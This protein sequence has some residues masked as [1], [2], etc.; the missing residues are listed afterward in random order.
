MISLR[1]VYMPIRRSLAS[2]SLA[3]LLPFLPASPGTFQTSKSNT[4]SCL[5]FISTNLAK[6]NGD[7][8]EYFRFSSKELVIKDGDTFVYSIFLDPR[9]PVAKGGVDIN[10]QDDGLPLRDLGLVDQEGIQA[11]GNGILQSAVGKWYT[12]RISLATSIGR[13][14]SDF[15]FQEEGDPD[16]TY[17]QFVADVY[18]EHADGSKTWIY[19]D[20][21]P[22]AGVIA[23]ENGYS[24][25]PTCVQVDRTQVETGK[26]LTPVIRAAVERGQAATKI[27]EIKKDIDLAKKYLAK[28][29]D[30]SLEG[31]VKEAETMLTQ[32]QTDSATLEQVEAVLHSAR[33]ALS[34][35]HPVMEKY[36]GHLVGHAHIDLQWLWEWQ[37]GIVFTHDTFNQAVKFMDEFPGFSFSQS[38]S[39]LYQ[40]TEQNYPDL[41]KK[42]QEKVHKGTWEIVGGRV[43]EGDTNMISLESHARQFLYGQRYFREKFGKT[44]VVG[45]EPDTFGHTAQMPQ[46]LKLGGC[47]YYYFCRGG[48]NKP[49]FWWS[50]LDG[51]KVLAFDE[52]ANGSWYNS[53][54][55]YRQFEEMLNFDKN[56]GS[57]DDLWVYGVGNHG[58]GPT[59]EQIEMALGWM[60][61][62]SKPKVKFSTATQFFNKLETYDLTKIPTVNTDL[63]P[64]FDGCYTSH[65]EI[66]QL[67]RDAEALTTSAEATAT[68]ASLYG[69]KYPKE[70]FR[71]DWEDI[72]FNHH[73]DTLP[74]SGIHAPYQ[75]TKVQLNRVLSDAQD[76][77]TR[78]LETM[79]IRVTPVQGGLSTLVFNPTGWKRDGWVETYLV[80]SGW[81]QGQDLDPNNCVAVGPDGKQ[82]PVELLDGPSRRARF[83]AGDVPPFG[84]KVF[85]LT[86]GKPSESNLKVSRDG[87]SI[88]T[89]RLSIE[90]DGTN[91]NVKSVIDKKT[92]KQ[93]AGK[94]GLGSLEAHME[95]A[96]G[97]SAWVL[98]HIDRVDKVKLVSTETSHDQT[99]ATVTF[100]YLLPS[101]NS[102]GKVTPITQKF[103]IDSNSSEIV[104]DVDCDW[105]AI[106]IEPG[107]NPLLR[108]AF[109][110]GIVNPVSTYEVPFGSVTR[111]NDGQEYPAL[112]WADLGGDGLGLSILNDSKH[113]YSVQGSTMRL[114]LIRSS[115]SPDPVPNPGKQHWRYAILPHAGDWRQAQTIHK[116]AEFNQ[117][118]LGA[119]VPFDAK[120][121]APLQYSPVS[122]TDANVIPTCLK[123]GEDSGDLIVRMYESTGKPS[124]SGLIFNVPIADATWVNFLEDNLAKADLSKSGV[125][126]SMRGFEIKTVKVKLRK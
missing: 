100:H 101:N 56:V 34:H 65:S 5:A 54:L 88:E 74:G 43:C 85:H 50:A 47:K 81:D 121:T 112:K 63:N 17:V 96:G 124:K 48:K 33:H 10:F 44:A 14:T 125:N 64:V 39:C 12:R 90:F 31:H 126:A 41:F 42:I 15:E 61:D 91:G 83:W 18:I 80:K 109:D 69:F 106:G 16:G 99:S 52:P 49:L 71:R 40:T 108:V 118:L 26:D 11:H 28:N 37:E 67:N 13:K 107:L 113:G 36:T 68:V 77:I 73:H 59:R 8:F 117:P 29:P 86:N 2:L 23:N 38:S 103:Q 35:T 102:V 57:K 20:G 21:P 19:Q 55:S 62:P 89:N 24:H 119:T 75:R 22:T 122:I 32:I 98:G 45:W 92:G 78:S 1:I 66:K 46:I 4:N 104:V 6:G 51:T 123:L 3:V 25:T 76:I 30:P 120:G 105:Q 115:F 60:K 110:S 82:Y 7:F 27:A 116:A 93:F 97:M 58:G 79:A 9:N 94:N 87:L 114:S 53:D 70:S 84:Y 111:P 95:R 72:C